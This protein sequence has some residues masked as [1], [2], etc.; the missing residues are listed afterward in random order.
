MSMIILSGL[1]FFS[2]LLLPGLYTDI[3]GTRACFADDGVLE[4]DEP[5]FDSSYLDG[6]LC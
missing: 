1:S 3:R 2:Q 5:W 4:R 6:P